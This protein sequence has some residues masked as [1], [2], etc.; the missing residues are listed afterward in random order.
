MQDGFKCGSC[1]Y[2]TFQ[3]KSECPSCGWVLE[4]KQVGRGSSHKDTEEI[5]AQKIA[6]MKSYM[7][8]LSNQLNELIAGKIDYVSLEIK[9]RNKLDVQ[10]RRLSKIHLS[11]WTDEDKEFYLRF[12]DYPGR[13][14]FN[15]FMGEF[16]GGN[17]YGKTILKDSKGQSELTRTIAGG[18][19]VGVL[20]NMNTMNKLNQLNET[21][22]EIAEDVEGASGGFDF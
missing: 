9:L 2:F 10:Y 6:E 21:V 15:D 16:V 17:N 3:E 7:G 22:D 13:K 19:A 1:G 18:V 12:R 4:A 20:A 11:K 14:E 5:R 8:D